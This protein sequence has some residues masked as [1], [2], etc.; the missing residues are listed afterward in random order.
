MAE[1]APPFWLRRAHREDKRVIK[2]LVR[3]AGLNPF[4][5]NW[6]R[7]TI[8][9]SEKDPIIGCVQAKPHRD[10]ALELASLVVKPAWRSHGVGGSL[11]A[12]V[13]A[14]SNGELWLMC[15]DTL[16]DYYTRFDFDI[17]SDAAQMTPYFWRIWLLARL[18]AKMTFR[19]E[20]PLAIM[21]WNAHSE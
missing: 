6:R 8:A 12:D 14:R 19:K 2:Y 1:A 15:R 11:I 3:S 16:T 10:G 4:G 7:F 20:S 21:R 18:F 13:K 9:A 17:I 5:L